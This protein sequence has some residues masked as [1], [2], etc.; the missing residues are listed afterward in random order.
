VEQASCLPLTVFLGFVYWNSAIAQIL[1]FLLRQYQ[2]E[3]LADGSR[4]EQVEAR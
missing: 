3:L 4:V 2:V 1:S